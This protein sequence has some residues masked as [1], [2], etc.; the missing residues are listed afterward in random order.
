M[1]FKA[2]LLAVVR[3]LIA[4]VL[5]SIIR[6]LVR[7]ISQSTKDLFHFLN[8]DREILKNVCSI[9]REKQSIK[10]RKY[11]QLCECPRKSDAIHIHGPVGNGF[12]S[13]GAGRMSYDTRK[14]S[15]QAL[16][17]LNASLYICGHHTLDLSQRLVAVLLRCPL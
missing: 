6:S 11:S 17:N 1:L 13:I 12:L 5:A 15:L 8:Q 4:N 7:R 3:E 9:Y 2:A 16:T 14:Q 10:T